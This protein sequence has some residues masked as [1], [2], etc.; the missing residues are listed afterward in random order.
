MTALDWRW[1]DPLHLGEEFQA[2]YLLLRS[3]ERLLQDIRRLPGLHKFRPWFL[4]VQLRHTLL[5][6]V[7]SFPGPLRSPRPHAPKEHLP[8]EVET[9]LKSPSLQEDPFPVLS[10]QTDG[11]VFG[12]SVR[13]DKTVV[14]PYTDRTS[15]TAPLSCENENSFEFEFSDCLDRLSESSATEE[16]IGP[17]RLIDFLDEVQSP[18]PDPPRDSAPRTP[19]SRMSSLVPRD[20]LDKRAGNPTGISTRDFLNVP[21]D[22]KAPVS[23]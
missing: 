7:R 15:P 23:T 19:S 18:R 9:A 16:T 20:S 13:K 6:Q 4:Q 17:V 8:D 12:V 5:P 14:T 21:L 3:R 11:A 1:L 22:S 2:R 10:L